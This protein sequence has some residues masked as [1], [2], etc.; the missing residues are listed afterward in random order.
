MEKLRFLAF[1]A[2]KSSFF[3]WNYEFLSIFKLKGLFFGF[4]QLFF[5]IFSPKIHQFPF[6][7]SLNSE[8]SLP[9]DLR[10]SPN[11]VFPRISSPF[12]YFPPLKNC[13]N[14]HTI[15]IF[16]T[17]QS[18][19]SSFTTFPHKNTY[20]SAA[21]NLLK[22]QVPTNTDVLLFQT[23]CRRRAKKKKTRVGLI[24][25]EPIQKSQIVLEMNGQVALSEEFPAKNG[26]Q[27]C[28][29]VRVEID[30]KV[31]KR[32]SLKTGKFSCFNAFSSIFSNLYPKISDFS[33]ARFCGR[34]FEIFPRVFAHFYSFL[35]ILH[36]IYKFD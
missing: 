6:Y 7:F 11:T 4:S 19:I 17:L 20:S 21:Y 27:G 30:M 31:L 32:K 23:R 26:K 29:K 9:S 33:G 16:Q 15:P 3:T 5:T 22:T 12:F 10:I 13:W 25:A 34:G 28:F 18:C 35:S 2:E 8:I 36:R 14:S 24:A 1:L